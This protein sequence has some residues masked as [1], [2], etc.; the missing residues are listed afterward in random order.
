L[1]V[2]YISAFFVAAA[3]LYADSMLPEGLAKIHALKIPSGIELDEY[4][5]KTPQYKYQGAIK[6]SWGSIPVDSKSV[7]KTKTDSAVYALSP[8]YGNFRFGFSYAPDYLNGGDSYWDNTTVQR[9]AKLYSVKYNV[10][11]PQVSCALSNKLFTSVGM[12]VVSGKGEFS[13]KYA[14]FYDISM[15][16]DGNGVSYM[17]NI[18]YKPLD[19]LLLSVSG[20][21]KTVVKLKGSIRSYSSF[22]TSTSSVKNGDLEMVLAPWYAVDATVFADKTLMFSASYKR[23]FG[24]DPGRVNIPFSNPSIGSLFTDITTPSSNAALYRLGVGKKLGKHAFA[25]GF[26]WSVKNIKQDSATLSSPPSNIQFA[27]FS[28]KYEISKS[29]SVGAKNVHV[30]FMEQHIDN[31]RLS[32]TFLQTSSNVFSMFIKRV[33]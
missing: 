26:G 18:A 30:R 16:G 8:E 11:L 27:N 31:S 14:P 12:N 25:G 5:A 10:F 23:V 24:A 17:A 32:G 22:P 2:K 33:F 21:S 3:G 19:M 7:A 28:Y 1:F 15:G 13:A 9:Y 4:I 20:T 29:W 6:G